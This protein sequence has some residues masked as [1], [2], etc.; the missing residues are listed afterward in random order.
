MSLSPKLQILM[1]STEL[2]ETLFRISY[3]GTSCFVKLKKVEK[4]PTN[5]TEY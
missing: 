3:F 2:G 1:P 5:H 4:S